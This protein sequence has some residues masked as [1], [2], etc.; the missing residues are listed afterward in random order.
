MGGRKK[1]EGVPRVLRK[2]QGVCEGRGATRTKEGSPPAQRDP[3]Q[4]DL[5]ER[6]PGLAPGPPLLRNL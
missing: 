2:R 6:E 3:N 1:G 4:G 5:L